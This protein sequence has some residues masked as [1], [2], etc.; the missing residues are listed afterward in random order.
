MAGIGLAIT[1]FKREKQQ[2]ISY[3]S[4]AEKVLTGR[5][6]RPSFQ[7]SED[8]LSHLVESGFSVPQIS[9]LLGVSIRTIERR[10]SHFG[11]RISVRQN[12][13]IICVFE[14]ERVIFKLSIMYC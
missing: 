1:C 9:L 5:P 12:L 10:L 11:I 3:E 14:L 4:R 7:V 8:Q 2:L 13:S 6:G